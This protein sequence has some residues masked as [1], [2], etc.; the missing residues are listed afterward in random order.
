[1]HGTG[2][3]KVIKKHGRVNYL[4]EEVSGRNRIKVVHIKRG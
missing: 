3:F 1:M 4:V 2:P